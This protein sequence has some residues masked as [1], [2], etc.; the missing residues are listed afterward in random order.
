MR[1]PHPVWRGFFLAVLLLS[2]LILLG[3]PDALGPCRG[4]R[5]LV[6]Y[7]GGIVI[8]SFVAALPGLFRRTRR[9]LPIPSWRRGLLA[10]AGGLGM[11]FALGLAGDGRILP[12]LL[13]GSP[14]A[15]AFCAMA[16]LTGLIT[17]RIAERRRA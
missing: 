9:P 16:L 6:C 5:R 10:L 17:R 1:I 15:F 2:G 14:G 4:D 8:G 7:A 3:M 11:A 12:V 13:S